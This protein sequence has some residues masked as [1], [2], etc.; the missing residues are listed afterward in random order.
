[1]DMDE[2]GNPGK[3]LAYFKQK[4]HAILDR[5]KFL[6][7]GHMST[8]R[9]WFFTLKKSI[10]RFLVFKTQKHPKNV[11]HEERKDFLSWIICQLSR[12][13]LLLHQVAKDY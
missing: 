3:V 11:P 5:F 7:V 12:V 13:L 9:I 10:H 4:N 8:I 2:E 1:M 6:V